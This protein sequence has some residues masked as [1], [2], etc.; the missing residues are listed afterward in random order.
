[1]QNNIMDKVELMIDYKTNDTLRGSFNT[2]A[3]ETFG[4][5]FEPWFKKGFWNDAYMCYSYALDGR[6]IAN[7]SINKMTLRLQGKSYQALQIGTVM[8]TPEYQ[9]M[10]LA[11][12]LFD[13]VV[14]EWEE[15]VDF[16]YLFGG[17][18]A[19]P[20]YKKFDMIAYDE[21]RYFVSCPK[22]LVKSDIRKLNL[23]DSED[24]D[25]MLNITHKRVAQ[26]D[27]I[28]VEKDSHLIMFYCHEWYADNLY[29]LEKED[30]ILVMAEEEEMLQL[31]DV[32][33]DEVKDVAKLL[34]L[35]VT[36]AD[37]VELHFKPMMCS[38]EIEEQLM[39]TD[40]RTLLIRQLETPIK[41]TFRFSMF[42]HA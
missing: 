13:I 2:L 10:G 35:I 21:H 38:R 40:D 28:G 27:A 34:S 25:L 16:I 20:L 14:K 29:Y 19:L 22:Q 36:E 33:A 15:K 4:I 5:N 9:R 7:V 32:L 6:I 37:K 17:D 41:E 31:Y 8:T 18:Q 23:K 12:N 3:T 11:Y 42:S 30:T 39:I 24:Y 1:M 26:S